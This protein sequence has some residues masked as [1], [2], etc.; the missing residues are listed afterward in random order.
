MTCSPRLAWVAGRRD[1]FGGG[2]VGHEMAGCDAVPVPFVG[3][4]ADDGAGAD[5]P[6]LADGWLVEAVAIGDVAGLPGGVSVPCG[7]GRRGESD[8][9]DPDVGGLLAA[10]GGLACGPVRT[11]RSR[12][13]SVYA[14][15]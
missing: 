15:A 1:G 7:A 12:A 11:R 2:Q 14:L 5:F 10:C 4:G 9:A 6:G 3:R 8:G 13:R